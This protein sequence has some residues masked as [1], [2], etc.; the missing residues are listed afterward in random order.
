MN[1][2]ELVEFN[3][4][5]LVYKHSRGIF[6]KNLRKYYKVSQ[7]YW[8]SLYH[9]IGQALQNWK[10]FANFISK[11]G[12]YY[13]AGKAIYYKLGQSLLHSGEI[14]ENGTIAK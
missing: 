7:L 13:K 11:Y 14:L 2:V 1:N 6:I 3:Y 12:K 5:E 8:D 10:L 9:K 4:F